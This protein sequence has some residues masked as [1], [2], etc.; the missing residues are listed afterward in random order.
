MAFN[1]RTKKSAQL[2]HVTNLISMSRLDGQMTENERDYILLVAK[3]FNLTQW[4]L[5]Q[6][7]KDSEKL[8]IDMPK[9]DEDKVEYMKN[10]VSMIFSEGTI[11]EQKRRFAE[12]I[13]EKFGYDGKETVDI[14][15]NELMEEIGESEPEEESEP[16]SNGEMTEEEFRE[17]LQRRLQKSAECFKKNDMSGVF[18]QLLYASIADSTSR[19]L[20]LRIPNYVYPMFMLTDK[21]V[22]ELKKLSDDGDA[23]AQYTL[24]RYYQLVRPSCEN[25]RKTRALFE[26]SAA[27]GLS[28]AYCGLA[29]LA[30]DGYYEEAD[31]DKYN[32]LMNE[33]GKKRSIKAFYFLWKDIIYGMNGQSANPQI[34]IDTMTD[35]LKDATGEDEKDIF[36]YDPEAYDLL[37]RAYQEAG[38]KEKAEDAYIRAVS[39]GY[40]ESLSRLAYMM[41]CDND[42]N[43]VE[44]EM[45]DQYIGIGIEHNDAWSYAM[46][47]L[48]GEDG[49][50]DLTSKE[51]V[52]RTAE[53]KADLEKASRLGDNIAPAILGKY[54]YYGTLGF[55]EDDEAA[56]KWFNIG[57]AYGS[58]ECY[59]MMAQMISEGHCPK[60]VSE[61]F[62]A[63]CILCAYRFGDEAKLVDVIQAYT[64]GL[65]DDFKNEIE[66]YCIPK[67][68]GIKQGNGKQDDSKGGNSCL[69]EIADM[70]IS[71]P[72]S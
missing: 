64:D 37:G 48:R 52:R 27:R 61:K 43:I 16:E 6:C 2:A 46:R 32:S 35:M 9:S 62:H 8:V 71:D 29:L 36:N 3:E 40:F 17:E 49:Y 51:K 12:H 39:M 65:L 13:C 26:A 28:E 66:K 38:Q 60:K 69:D 58:S 42:G 59:S 53:I 1:Y 23:I 34:V 11:D 7:M 25:L 24:G 68:N 56:W 14:L 10:L 18:D 63:F 72:W 20:F 47:G 4:E 33:A 57:S 50:D 30:R 31:P 45:F 55:D 19:R 41:C 15:F 44:K 22:G 54:Y 67:F 5:D 21:Q 70:E